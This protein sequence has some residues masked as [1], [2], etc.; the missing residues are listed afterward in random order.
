MK[1]EKKITL[2][3]GMP[4]K[5]VGGKLREQCQKKKGKSERG[6][7]SGQGLTKLYF[8]NLKGGRGEKR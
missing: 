2:A 5:G 3:A 8:E 6:L 1:G 7:E 4:G